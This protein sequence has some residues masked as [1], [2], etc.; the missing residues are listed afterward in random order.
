MMNPFSYDPWHR[1]VICRACETR[2]I[3]SDRG[4]LQTYFPAKGRIDYFVVHND[5]NVAVRGGDV[6]GG[7]PGQRSLFVSR[8]G[9]GT[10]CEAGK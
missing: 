5:D 6:L 3:P 4:K 8:A 10:I 2:I 9:E 1:V 7:T